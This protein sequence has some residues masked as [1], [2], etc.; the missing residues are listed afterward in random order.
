[1]FPHCTFRG[2]KACDCSVELRE[3]LK[4]ST[5]K[6]LVVS[7]IL[8]VLSAGCPPEAP[9][10]CKTCKAD[11]ADCTACNDNYLPNQQS[12]TACYKNESKVAGCAFAGSDTL[13]IGCTT[14]ML[15]NKRGIVTAC[16]TYTGSVGNCAM[17]SDKGTCVG[18]A[19]GFLPNAKATVKECNKYTGPAKNCTVA[20]SASA[21]TAC[22]PGFKLHGTGDSATCLVTP[23]PN[24]TTGIIVGV[25]VGV[26]I[27]CGILTYFVLLARERKEHAS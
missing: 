15:P 10:N 24:V 4:K 7:L 18:C 3:F 22:A 13:C 20:S 2:A 6:M 12:I 19:S 16:T 26:G 8:A 17:A 5:R 1:M 21:C 25:S 14:G 9:Q 27:I 11:S 23:D